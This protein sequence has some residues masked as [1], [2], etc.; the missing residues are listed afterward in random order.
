MMERS[1]EIATVYFWNRRDGFGF[2]R[3]RAGRNVFFNRAELVKS[4]IKKLA[5]GD[6]L[7][8]EPRVD[9]FGRNIRAIN[10]RVLL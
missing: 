6:R 10:V 3:G 4:G 1:T 5:V 2:A 7:S 8:F 9:H